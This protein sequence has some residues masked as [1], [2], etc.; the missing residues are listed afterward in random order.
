MNKNVAEELEEHIIHRVIYSEELACLVMADNSG[1]LPSKEKIKDSIFYGKE[2][3]RKRWLLASNATSEIAEKFCRE[4]KADAYAIES[5]L[6]ETWIP[7]YKLCYEYIRDE[8][9]G[10]IR[11][12]E[13]EINKGHYEYDHWSEIVLY[14]LQKKK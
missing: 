14:K 1:E 5:H 7:S 10:D 2:Y 6:K 9:T 13:Y 12:D 8:S 4:E 3:K 11:R